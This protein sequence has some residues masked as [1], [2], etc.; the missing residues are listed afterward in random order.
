MA[1]QRCDGRQLDPAVVPVL[2]QLPH[3][4]A[5]I[6]PQRRLE[7]LEHAPA[8]GIVHI[9]AI[10]GIHHR[11][12]PQLAAVVQVGD[13]RRGELEDA[14]DYAIVGTGGGQA[15]RERQKGAKKCAGAR[16]G[17]RRI[18]HARH[19]F[20]ILDIG[21]RPTGVHP[22]FAH[23]LQHRLAHALGI[24]AQPL[25]IR[26]LQLQQFARPGSRQQLVQQV[27]IVAVG[28]QSG[29]GRGRWTA[30]DAGPY[31][32][33]VRPFLGELRQRGQPRARV[34]AALG[35]VGGGGEQR[36]R[37]VLHA[38]QISLVECA[39]GAAEALRISAHFIHSD[40]TV[41]AVERRVF[42]ALG[43]HR[44][45]VLLQPH[46]AS[47][48]RL[49]R[50]AA[51][52][53]AHQIAGQHLLEKAEGARID[54]GFVAPRLGQRPAQIVLVGL[55]QLAVAVDVGTV[56]R[57]TR[58]QLLDRPAQQI[59]GEVGGARVLACQAR[60]VA[61]Q[62]IELARHLIFHDMEFGQARDLGERSSL[63]GEFGITVREGG[64]CAAVDQQRQHLI[65]KI[66][67][68]GAVHRPVGVQSLMCRQYLLDYQVEVPTRAARGQASL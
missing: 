14:L 18:D 3:A 63:A 12:V 27:L 26:R 32:Q 44:S 1:Q 17:Q 49:A 42:D 61:G 35:V 7:L 66:V 38:L 51:A 41:I 53:L 8:R 57:K 13:S 58:D 10:V 54:F 55:I 59:A 5:P 68:G 45:A 48:Q 31:R 43:V 4:G 24:G 36:V 40:E 34:L 11:Q 21:E 62:H 25:V 29:L 60:H 22:C 6:G 39:D 67:A 9:A 33:L 64:F 47:Q 2:P 23:R 50:K 56:H 65:E 37:P 46:R 16:T 15:A 52:W 28:P 30:Q 19:R 20:F